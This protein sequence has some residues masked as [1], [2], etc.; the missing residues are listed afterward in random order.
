[1]TPACNF[2][3]R[4]RKILPSKIDMEDVVYVHNPALKID[5]E[6]VVYVHNGILLSHRK[7]QNNAICSNMDGNGESNTK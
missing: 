5:M 7:E 3:Q 4:A 1:M 6:D 2:I